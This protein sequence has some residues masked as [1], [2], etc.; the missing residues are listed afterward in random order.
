MNIRIS[1]HT[2][3]IKYQLLCLLRSHSLLAT[4]LTV[5][6]QTLTIFLL[7]KYP[8]VHFHNEALGVY[9]STILVTTAMMATSANIFGWQYGSAFLL[10]ISPSS[11]TRRVSALLSLLYYVFVAVVLDIVIFYAVQRIA[12]TPEKYALFIICFVV[13]V[14]VAKYEALMASNRQ[15][16]PLK[17][18]AFSFSEKTPQPPRA[19]GTRIVSTFLPTAIPIGVFYTLGHYSWFWFCFV[20]VYAALIGG[21]LFWLLRSI[22]QKAYAARFHLYQSLKG[23]K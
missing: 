18:N 19:P 8:S 12:F 7:W 16:V 6:Q 9:F 13:G 17:K 22:P 2:T 4:F 14:A 3:Y 1:L 23:L 20:V 15:A 10:Y 5:V 21:V 11:L